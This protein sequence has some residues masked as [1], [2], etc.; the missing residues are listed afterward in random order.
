MQVRD[1]IAQ[2]QQFDPYARVQIGKQYAVLGASKSLPGCVAI[3]TDIRLTHPDFLE[4]LESLAEE[5]TTKI[6]QLK[7]QTP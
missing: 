4:E 3:D 6:N 5:L 7:P 2:L 1:L